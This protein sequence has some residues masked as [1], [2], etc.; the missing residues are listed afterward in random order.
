[1][2]KN[3]GVIILI[4]VVIIFVMMVP[5][6]YIKN[7]NSITI[8]GSNRA[9]L[10]EK[11]EIFDEKGNITVLGAPM[12]SSGTK[13]DITRK[14]IRYTLPYIQNIA[15][16][17]LTGLLYEFNNCDMVFYDEHGFILR[18][19]KMYRNDPHIRVTEFPTNV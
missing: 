18:N 5:V 19:L 11:V 13:T 10:L 14:W 1:M 16:M 4:I 3:I 6:Q 8:I 2:N 15:R 17:R 7:V 12:V 9:H